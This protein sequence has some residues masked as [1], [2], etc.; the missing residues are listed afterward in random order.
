MEPTDEHLPRAGAQGRGQDTRSG[1]LERLQKACKISGRSL[2]FWT[3]LTKGLDAASLALLVSRAQLLSTEFSSS[4]DRLQQDQ[5]EAVSLFS[6][7][8][9]RDRHTFLTALRSLVAHRNGQLN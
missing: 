3:D 6:Q 9:P 1:E 5:R 4:C 2:S 7:I 8:G